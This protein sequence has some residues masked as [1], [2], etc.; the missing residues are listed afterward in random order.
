[1]IST[2]AC[3]GYAEQFHAKIPTLA[4]GVDIDGEF[5]EPQWQHAVEIELKYETSPAENTLAPVMTKAKMFATDTSLFFAFIA[6][7]PHPEAI[8]ANLRDRDKSWGDDLVGIKLDTFNNARLA[9]QFFINPLGVQS[10]S[11]ENELTGQESDAWDGIWYSKGKITVQGYQVEVELPLRLFNFDDNKD[12]Q[13]WGFELIR[14]YPRNE[15][16]RFSTHKIDRNVSCKLCQLGTIEGLAGAS[17]GQD[18]QLTPSLVA[19]QSN[20]RPLNPVGEW[21]DDTNVEVG[22]DLRWG[23]T[24]TTLL[25]ATIN[26]DFSQVEAD[27]GQLDVNNTFAL[28]YPEKRAFFLD[29]KDYFDS[30]LNLLHTRNISSPDYGLKLTSKTDDHTIAVLA[31]N[32]TQT[33]FLVPGNL[34]SDIA[35]LNQESYNVAARYRFDPSNQFSIG[36]IVTLKQAEDYHNYVYSGDVKYQPTEQDTFTAQ[37]AFSQTQ[38]PD[39]LFQSFCHGADCQI[40]PTTCDLSNCDYNERVL[41][42]NKQGQFNDNMYK[43]TYNHNRRNW[44]ANARYE[45][46]GD[47]FRGDLGFIEKV[48]S[49]KFVAG[50]GY[51]WYPSDSFFSKINLGGDWDITHTQ[52]GE[53]LEQETEMFIE[54]EGGYQSYIASG[55]ATRERVGRRHNPSIIDIDNNTQMFNE[56]MGWFYTN[57]VPT[58][59]LKLELDVNYGDNI[60]FANDRLGTLTMFN[61]GLEWKLTNSIVVNASHR[62]QTLDVDGGRLFRANLTD[63]RLNWQINLNSFIRLTSV[64]TNIKRDPN[65]YLYQNPNKL[66]QDLGNEVLYGYKLNPQSVFYLGYSDAFSA[67]DDIDSLTQNEKTY[68][69]KVSY[70]WLL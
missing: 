54:F 23:I 10:D 51:K 18:I 67:N 49:A 14:F 41:R 2:H 65:L 6:Y 36:G 70:A 11:I 31:T 4:Q 37:Y 69:M 32:D 56:V 34:S 55:I 22:L 43:L 33:Q 39:D 35:T 58:Q 13:T 66:Y 61:P 15:T 48:D 28:F 27:A 30:Q 9:Y 57:F 1:M 45:S 20:Q 16:H 29:N 52:N 47:D 26:P 44:Y 42:T 59:A 7:D 63:V 19:N 8:R 12:I 50:G 3:G 46:I 21:D 24:P 68:F 25:N 38:Y 53:R 40:P 62:Y 5:N 64:Y 17:Q 60:D